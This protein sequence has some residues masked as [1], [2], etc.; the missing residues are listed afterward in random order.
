MIAGM[1]QSTLKS[2]AA[3]HDCAAFGA[4]AE[5]SHERPKG[6]RI[7][8]RSSCKAVSDGTDARSAADGLMGGVVGDDGPCPNA[9]E[10]ELLNLQR[11][12]STGHI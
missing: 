6:P 9:A 10:P 12:L 8:V 5:D 2:G 1:A 7:A 3:T 11:F 4:S